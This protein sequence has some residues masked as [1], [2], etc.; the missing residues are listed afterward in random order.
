MLCS[1]V[2]TPLATA[3]GMGHPGPLFPPGE[4]GAGNEGAGLFTDIVTY[5]SIAA[6]GLVSSQK[7]QMQREL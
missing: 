7:D 1:A 5:L 2:L 3:D 4:F 6:A